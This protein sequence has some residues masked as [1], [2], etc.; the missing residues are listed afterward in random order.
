MISML[1]GTMDA[2]GGKAHVFCN[3]HPPSTP[4]HPPCSPLLTPARHPAH[5]HC[6]PL[7]HTPTPVTCPPP[8]THHRTL[9]HMAY[10]MDVHNIV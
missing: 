5:H 4:A 2:Q 1:L 6:R 3:F 8:L 9:L 10:V 7:D